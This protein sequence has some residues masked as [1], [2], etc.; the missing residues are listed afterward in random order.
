L[1]WVLAQKRAKTQFLV[2]WHPA[3]AA[4]NNFVTDLYSANKMSGLWP[5]LRGPKKA[6]DKLAAAPAATCGLR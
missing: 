2:P 6:V 5:G 4:A 3:V 1:R